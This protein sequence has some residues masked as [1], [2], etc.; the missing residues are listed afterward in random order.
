MGVIIVLMSLW[1]GASCLYAYDLMGKDLDEAREKFSDTYFDRYKLL[2]ERMFTP[3]NSGRRLQGN[4]VER[5]LE[6][7]DEMRE[8]E[9]PVDG[10]LYYADAPTGHV[11][12][13]EGHTIDEKSKL[14][15]DR[16]QDRLAWLKNFIGVVKYVQEKNLKLVY[17]NHFDSDCAALSGVL[18]VLFV[19]IAW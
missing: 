9:I 12:S 10:M 2:I 7:R 1:L 11:N 15:A 13:K 6:F 18:C 5:L 17:H 19:F 3:I 4:A 14:F 8:V 16:L